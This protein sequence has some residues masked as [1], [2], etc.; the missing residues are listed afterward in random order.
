MADVLTTSIHAAS[1]GRRAAAG[2]GSVELTVGRLAA[3]F[4]VATLLVAAAPA[5]AAPDGDAARA[6]ARQNRCFECH[7]IDK[8]SDGPSWKEVA[9]KYRGKTEAQA[10]LMTHL[11]TGETAKFADGH[12][13]PHKIVKAPE[14]AQIV[15]LVAWILSL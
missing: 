12:E 11:T 3:G 9:A 4:A 6:L 7:A 13:E 8:K 2:R 1:L 5:Y 10:R 14:K 15:N